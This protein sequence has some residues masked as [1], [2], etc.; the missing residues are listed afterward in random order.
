M[1]TSTPVPETTTP[2]ILET[3]DQIQFLLYTNEQQQ[4]DY[5]TVTAIPGV[6]LTAPILFSGKYFP[7]FFHFQ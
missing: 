3:D 5:V 4:M 1:V 7:L 6:N 2:A